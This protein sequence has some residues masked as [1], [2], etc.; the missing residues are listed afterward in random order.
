MTLAKQLFETGFQS[1]LSASLGL[2][3]KQVLVP[4]AGIARWAF[5]G[6]APAVCGYFLLT[7]SN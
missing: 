6:I 3:I 7:N 4:D 1:P 5:A 2:F